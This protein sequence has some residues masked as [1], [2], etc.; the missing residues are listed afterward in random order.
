VIHDVSLGMLPWR[1]RWRRTGN[2]SLEAFELGGDAAGLLV[3]AVL[4][5]LCLVGFL[6]FPV[7]LFAVELAVLLLALPMVYLLR[8]CRI[9]RWPVVSRDGAGRVVAVEKHRGLRRARRRRDQIRS[10]TTA[11]GVPARR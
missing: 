7:V 8:L 10:L 11:G 9:L 2:L 5:I 4:L 1:L 6:I 3:G